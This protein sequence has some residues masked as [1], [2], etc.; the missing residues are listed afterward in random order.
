MTRASYEPPRV[1][2]RRL[3][4]AGI[5][6]VVILVG[7]IGGWAAATNISGAVVAA[8]LMVVDTSA[9]KVQHPSGGIVGEIRVRDGDRV[10]AGDMLV[11]LDETVT[12][13][14]LAIVIN[15]LNEL[16]AR[17][18]RLEAERDIA[19]AIM[20]TDQLLEDARTNTDV[21]RL[22]ASESKVFDLRRLARDGQKAL[23][24]ERSAQLSEEI[25]GHEGQ[26][27]GKRQEIELIGRELKGARELYNK[28]LMPITKMTAL[29]RDAARL[30]GER[31]Q[32]LAAIAQG[33][34]KIAETELQ[35]LQIDR[36]AASE[37][38]KELREIE[39][40]I[41]ELVERKVAAEDQ[42]RRIDIRAP[43]DG[44][45]HQS[46]VHTIGGVISPGEQLM[47]IV[48]EGEKLI[49]EL[50]VAPQ[51]IDQLWIGQP[52]NLRF[53]AFDQRTT[54]EIDGVVSHVSADVTTEERTGLDYYTVRI[55]TS[56]GQIARLGEVRLV[57]GMPVEGFIKT[58]ERRVL[59]YLLK[60]LSDQIA[61]AFR[62]S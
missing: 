10:K 52:A 20:F 38:G 17:K 36:D 7:G 24:A 5:A 44:I 1:A 4:R 43:Q 23:L 28:N 13:A 48:P 49:A 42:M 31:S 6:T 56:G 41:G 3:M 39:A 51:D 46:V 50:K 60:P 14:N 33:R 62:E 2:I 27:V 59:T 19:S 57:P 8:G 61:R 30:Q 11:R 18:A 45:V 16:Y 21:A 40:K 29:E 22:L 54:P 35:I 53:P 55:A 26:E 34:G 47:L 9:K 58:G 37:I 32:L 15:N 25:K 12:R